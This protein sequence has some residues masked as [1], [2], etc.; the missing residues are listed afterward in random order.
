[1][2]TGYNLWYHIR[3]FFFFFTL[4]GYFFGHRRAVLKL[5]RNK[6]LK[7]MPFSWLTPAGLQGSFWT[8]S[9]ETSWAGHWVWPPVT[10]FVLPLFLD[11][12]TLFFC[13]YLCFIPA[14]LRGPW[15]QVPGPC[16]DHGTDQ[17]LKTH[18]LNLFKKRVH[19]GV[20]FNPT[21]S[22]GAPPKTSLVWLLEVCVSVAPT[23][24]QESCLPVFW[25]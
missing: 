2:T 1:M 23:G 9:E 4:K 18:W 14:G 17:P 25:E 19:F 11:P 8:S 13:L 3:F 24:N 21:S 16:L 5:F 7:E 15:D 6:K 22:P 20:Q 12:Q 10:S